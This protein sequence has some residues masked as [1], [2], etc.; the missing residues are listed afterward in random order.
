M[1]S[2]C[3]EEGAFLCLAT[4]DRF[5]D[6]EGLT[7]LA[8]HECL[9]FYLGGAISPDGEPPYRNS[10]ELVWLMEGVT[11]YLTF[12]LLEDAG[13]LPAGAT[14][15]A[16]RKKEAELAA[17]PEPRISLAEAA[18]RM[19]ETSV[20]T[21]VYSRGFLVG[22]LLEERMNARAPGSFEAA[23]RDLFR[24]HNFYATRR[25]VGSDEVRAVFEARCP[26]IGEVIDRYATGGG[27]LPPAGNAEDSAPRPATGPGSGPRAPQ[28]TNG[29]GWAPFADDGIEP[30]I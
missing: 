12:R 9:H 7:V 14:E 17:S 8:A 15:R 2:G 28:S 27:T 5:R 19:E 16:A 29:A 18:R 3:S 13:S 25:T 4:R 26:G 24:G 20:Y 10:P 6:P 30:M 1:L 11:E 23:L 22:R 21:L